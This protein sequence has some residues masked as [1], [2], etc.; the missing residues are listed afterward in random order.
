MQASPPGWL[1][2]T[3]PCLASR[4]YPGCLYDVFKALI[5]PQF[6]RPQLNFASIREHRRCQALAAA[7]DGYTG[8]DLAA[9]CREAA[10]A[11]L[12]ED[13]DAV[14]VAGRHFVAALRAV[15]PSPPP[16][17]P[18]AAVYERFQRTGR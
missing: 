1:K 5:G 11:A 10:L 17:P 9:V 4:P 8:A 3:R 12:E 2:I 14:A 15:R 13:I 6:L 16:P 7:S 18:L